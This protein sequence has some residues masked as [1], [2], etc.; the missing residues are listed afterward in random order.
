MRHGENTMDYRVPGPVAY[1]F[2]KSDAFIRGIRG[3]VGSGKSTACIMDMWATACMQ[4]PNENGRRKYRGLII[5][6][7]YGELESTTLKSFLMW[8]P[9]TA[10]RLTYGAP[11][12]YRLEKRMK[13]G[14][15]LDAEFLFLAL[16]RPE[17][18][19]KLLSLEVTQA[20]MNEA[21]EQVKAVLDHLTVR[22]GRYPAIIDGG[23]V[24]AGV[25]MDTNSP[26]T[27][28]WWPKLSD[29]A[30]PAMLEQMRAVEDEMR[31]IGA[32]PIGQ[33]L[34]EFFTQPGAEGPNGKLNP[35]AENI[36][37][38]PLGY[39]V[40]AKLGK[41]NEWIKVYI[42]NEYG[43]VMDGK[44]VYPE[45]SD[46]RHCIAKPFIP[47]LPLHMGIDFGLTPAA[48]FS[49]R[50]PMGQVRWLSELVA[51]RLGAKQ[52]AREIKMHLANHY[53]GA[54][55][56][57]IT[58]D[59]AG[60]AASQADEEVTPFKMLASEGVMAKPAPTNDFEIRR[61]AVATPMQQFIDGEP[62]LVIHPEMRMTRKG[63]AGGYHFRRIKVSDERYGDKP[64]KNM[65]SHVCEAGQ[66]NNLGLGIGKDVI[67]M[68]DIITKQRANRPAFA[69]MSMD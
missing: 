52:F 55:I 27:D 5:R 40:R 13:D 21:R 61:E 10:G 29:L 45:Y 44:A 9:E 19:R 64:E 1:R 59:P 43:F 62:G 20:W 25:I 57:N 51:T 38:L 24:R 2:L 23:A 41:T 46:N 53:P 17:H 35:D 68:P 60:N 37:N 33:K 3:P 22:V 14:T 36:D 6:N 49:Q 67:V 8:F 16:D 12:E 42:R 32:L 48:I 18:V 56:G 11:I 66:Y 26:D 31:S 7:T 58:G 30:D 65:F 28:H 63:M 47:S 69:N 50:S 4:K 15:I 34:I 54:I 39:Y